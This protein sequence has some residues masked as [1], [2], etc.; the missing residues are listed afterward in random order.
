[1]ALAMENG[2]EE[3]GARARQVLE[4]TAKNLAER[5]QDLEKRTDDA[6]DKLAGAAAAYSQFQVN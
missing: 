1:M 2:G 4:E 6:R 3:A 5:L